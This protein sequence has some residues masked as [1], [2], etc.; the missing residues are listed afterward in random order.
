MEGSPPQIDGLRDDARCP[1]CGA[2]VTAD[3]EWCGQCFASLRPD[4]VPREE[5][6]AKIGIN[7]SEEP[8]PRLSWTCPACEQENDIELNRCER[9]GTSFAALMKAEEVPVRVEPMEALKW[10]LICPGLGHRKAGRGAE[11][12]ARGMAFSLSLILLVVVA[13]STHGSA[14]EVAMASLY[15]VTTITLYLGSAVEAYRIAAGGAPFVSSRT[16]MWVTVGFLL[17]S[18]ALLA[19]TATV[20][21]RR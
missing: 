6:A 2:L 16:L 18:I 13:L 7:V 11:G 15:L 8:K 5:P 19:I 20:S 4:P 9:C 3:A 1:S 21:A 12:V 17:V 14:G 10:S